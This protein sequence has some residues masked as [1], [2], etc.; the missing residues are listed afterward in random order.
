MVIEINLEVVVKEI[1][2][3]LVNTMQEVDLILVLGNCKMHSIVVEVHS[4]LF[5]KRGEILYEIEDILL[6]VCNSTV[7]MVYFYL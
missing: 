2:R 7:Q 6:Q 4:L 3:I 5:L 1:V